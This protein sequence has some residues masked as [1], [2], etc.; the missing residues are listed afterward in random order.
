MRWPRRMLRLTASRYGVCL[1]LALVNAN[2]AK[3]LALQI[4]PPNY[5]VFRSTL[6]QHYFAV[7]LYD[8]FKSNVSFFRF[9]KIP[10]AEL[11]RIPHARWEP[12]RHRNVIGKMT[13]FALGRD[14]V[15]KLPND[16]GIRCRVL[17]KLA[18]EVGVIVGAVPA[19]VRLGLARSIV[20]VRASPQGRNVITGGQRLTDFLRFGFHAASS[21][22]ARGVLA[23]VIDVIEGRK[24]NGPR[25]DSREK[26]KC[27]CLP[28]SCPVVRHC[29]WSPQGSPLAGQLNDMPRQGRHAPRDRLLGGNYG[30]DTAV[31]LHRG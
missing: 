14:P 26:A 7:P 18:V 20:E 31:G 25:G 22:R 10:F 27:C 17:A 19:L 4:H 2:G 12:K 21:A 5:R 23:E 6:V 29:G 8:D 16:L 15:D 28:L 11:A 3:Y 30:S 9:H 13:D 24:C 1:V